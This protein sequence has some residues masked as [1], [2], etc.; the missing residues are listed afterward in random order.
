MWCAGYPQL[1]F[2][3]G[4][5]TTSSDT[6]RSLLLAGAT[7]ARLT[8]SYGTPELQAERATQV[9]RLAREIGANVFLVADLQGEKC[10]LSS[11]AGIDEIPVQRGDV[12]MLVSEPGALDSSPIRLQ[13]QLPRYLKE[14]WPGDII[15]EGDGAISLEVLERRGDDVMCRCL[16][17]GKLR[18]GRGIVLQKREFR[19]TALTVKDR[20]D[21]DFVLKSQ[22]FDA[23][24]VSF[25]GTREDVAQVK[26]LLGGQAAISV[27]AKIETQLGVDNVESIVAE[28]DA[29]MAARG[30]L[31]LT[32]P[33]EQLPASVRTIAQASQHARKPWILATQIAEGMERFS[34]PTR[35]EICDSPY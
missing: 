30:D 26:A 28:A 16:A 7:G 32:M 8:F 22:L 15:L 12:V 9:R 6:I 2:T 11:L 27:I 35:A 20:A 13:V 1:W 19:P 33:W 31:A 21:L 5:K 25:V 3:Y 18:P 4:P 23:V 24:A 17:T 14:M 29:V 34:F 10:R